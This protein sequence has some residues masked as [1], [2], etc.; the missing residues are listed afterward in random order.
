MENVRLESI[1]IR[2]ADMQFTARLEWSLSPVTCRNFS[3]ILLS[4]PSCS[5]RVGVERRRG[6]PW[7]DSTWE[8][9]A[10]PL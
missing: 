8:S 6:F 9:D 4:A 5:K 3:A 10:K 1:R 2:I 7:L